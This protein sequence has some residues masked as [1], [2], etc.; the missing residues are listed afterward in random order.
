MKTWNWGQMTTRFVPGITHNL[1][2]VYFFQQATFHYASCR[3]SRPHKSV[4]V[5]CTLRNSTTLFYV[6]LSPQLFDL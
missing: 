3:L 5:T 4:T 2:T 6:S 1:S